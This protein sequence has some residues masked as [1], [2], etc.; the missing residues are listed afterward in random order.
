MRLLLRSSYTKSRQHGNNLAQNS[1]VPDHTH[2]TRT[3]QKPTHQNTQTV[4]RN[5]K[6][7]FTNS[8]LG[9]CSHHSASSSS[10][11][12]TNSSS[13]S[14]APQAAQPVIYYALHLGLEWISNGLYFQSPLPFFIDDVKPM[15]QLPTEAEKKKKRNKK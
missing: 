14:R 6:Y 10:C 8:A 15:A 1:T 2:H 7:K 9:A 3:L 5:I 13:E 12:F 4:H 11:S